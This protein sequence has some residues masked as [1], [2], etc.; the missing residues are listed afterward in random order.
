[1]TLRIDEEAAVD[2]HRR[3]IHIMSFVLRVFCTV[4]LQAYAVREI[5]S[6]IHRG[7][8]VTPRHDLLTLTVKPGLNP[9]PNPAMSDCIIQAFFD[10]CAVMIGLKLTNALAT[11]FLF[12]TMTII[13]GNKLH[14]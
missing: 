1:M 6:I 12:E 10:A 4:H 8:T 2:H 14:R 7:A 11:S 3:E 5:L 13:A 9:N